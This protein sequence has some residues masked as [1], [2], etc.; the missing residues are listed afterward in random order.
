MAGFI[1]GKTECFS[2]EETALLVRE[3]KVRKQTIYGTADVRV[4]VCVCVYSLTS[5]AKYVMI[6]S[7]NRSNAR[8]DLCISVIQTNTCSM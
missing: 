2:S 6:D 4:E 8:I 1:S 7:D 5:L 3:V